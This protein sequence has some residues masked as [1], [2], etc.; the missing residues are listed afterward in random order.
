MPRIS[1]DYDTR[2]QEFLD[3][4]QELFYS[5]GY[6]Q[7][8]V[9][10]IL[11]KVG[12]AKGTFYHYFDS[13]DDLLNALTDRLTQQTLEQ[14]QPIV[15]NEELGAIEKLNLYTAGG[16]EAKVANTELI[17]A[18]MR[19][20][21]KDENIILRYKMRTRSIEIVAPVLSKIIQQGVH[22]GVMDASNPDQ[23]AEMVIMLG[24]DLGEIFA[25]LILGLDEKP[26]NIQLIEDRLQQYEEAV[27]R[28]LGAP[29][30]A[31]TFQG[32]KDLLEAFR[33]V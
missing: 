25:D 18:W 1:K 19:V 5:N 24:H 16:Q 28:I 29:Q 20:M 11:E 31:I 6:E 12:V 32:N 3:A 22:E 8:S 26:E 7:T 33:D 30:G 23:A 17:K 4:A 27:T 10:M 2:R 14:L 9:N 21:Y 15:D 13:K